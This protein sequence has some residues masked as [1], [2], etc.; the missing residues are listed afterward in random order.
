MPIIPTAVYRGRGTRG[1]AG[2]PTL[3]RGEE[4]NFRTGVQ[5]GV[6]MQIYAVTRGMGGHPT[7]QEKGGFRTGACDCVA[8]C[9]VETEGKRAAETVF[10]KHL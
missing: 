3:Q 5:K 8:S 6:C 2:W 1:A 4:P 10:E 9:R 7:L